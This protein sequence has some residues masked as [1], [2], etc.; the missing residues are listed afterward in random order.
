MSGFAPHLLQAGK[1]AAKRGT[2]FVEASKK[3]QSPEIIKTGRPL[4]PGELIDLLDEEYPLPDV[5]DFPPDLVDLPK[6]TDGVIVFRDG[7]LEE[8][9]VA[10]GGEQ[11]LSAY[12]AKGGEWEKV[13]ASNPD[14]LKVFVTG[15]EF[16]QLPAHEKSSILKAVEGAGGKVE[17]SLSLTT[18]PELTKEG[19][20]Q[21]GRL[22][23]SLRELLNPKVLREKISA[24]LE[25]NPAMRE[26]LE[27][28]GRK[29]EE[30][31]KAFLET[32][33][34]LGNEETSSRPLTPKESDALRRNMGY[35]VG[36]W[37]K[38]EGTEVRAK[39]EAAWTNPDAKTAKEG[40]IKAN[41]E[42]GRVRG[43]LLEGVIADH[44]RSKGFDVK[45][46]V[47]GQDGDSRRFTDIRVMIEGK[48]GP[49]PYD[50]ELKTGGGDYLAQQ[51]RLDGKIDSNLR[52]MEGRKEVWVSNEFDKLPNAEQIRERLRAEGIQVVKMLPDS[53]LP[54]YNP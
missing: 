29:V 9:V 53:A 27:A 49:I 52:A 8:Y 13:I 41:S 2:E 51:F 18:R 15:P 17:T 14:T 50:I 1:E 54:A 26:R 39:L 48:D 23:E 16:L 24:Y 30:Q 4:T 40:L 45:T 25:Q 10:K 19:K 34:Q 46:E 6:P 11:E 20:E 21:V 7:I 44:L 5:A 33:Q 37:A 42:F 43:D 38:M 47:A 3:W 36:E 35:S 12:F 28:L 32:A 31:R 22:R